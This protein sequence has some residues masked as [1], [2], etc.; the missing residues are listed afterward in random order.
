M[1]FITRAR[2]ATVVAVFS[3][4]VLVSINSAAAQGTSRRD[5]GVVVIRER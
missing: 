5:S 1:S 4:G 3:L 2:I